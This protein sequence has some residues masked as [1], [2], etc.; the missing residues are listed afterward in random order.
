MCPHKIKLPKKKKRKTTHK[1]S[2]INIRACW[3]G[4]GGEKKL[5]R[6]FDV[7]L[8]TYRDHFGEIRLFPILRR[9]TA[10]RTGRT[11]LPS[12]HQCVFNT[13]I[14]LT[15]KYAGIPQETG[16]ALP[17]NTGSF[18]TYGSVTMTTSPMHPLGPINPVIRT[19]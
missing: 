16:A 6:V 18:R 7:M 5:P 10:L 11:A 13:A 9:N 12:M 17:R 15:S 2:G 4:C 8:K 1:L 19:L 14:I 3:H